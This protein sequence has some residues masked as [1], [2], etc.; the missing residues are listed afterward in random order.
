MNIATEADFLG[1]YDQKKLISVWVLF[2][3]VTELWGNFNCRKRIPVNRASQVA[4][5]DLEPAGTGR[6]RKLQLAIRAV[7]KRAAA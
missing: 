7:H 5:C 6:Q 2:S 4:L 3:K 1:L